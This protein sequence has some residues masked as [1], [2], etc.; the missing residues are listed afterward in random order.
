MTEDD[1]SSPQVTRRALGPITRRAFLKGTAAGVSWSIATP[2]SA[3]WAYGGVSGKVRHYDAAVP[4][5]HAQLVLQLVA[6]TPGFTPPVASRALGYFGVALY[7]S[8]VPGMQGYRSLHGL[9]PGFPRTP[10]TPRSSLH[11]PTVA[12]HALG[13]ILRNLFPANAP[14]LGTVGSLIDDIDSGFS[15]PRPIR[16]RSIDRGVEIANVVGEWASTDGG[17]GGHLTNFPA[18][19]VPVSGPGLWEPTPPALQ[20]IPL[21][22]F[23]GQNR[24]FADLGCVAPP[25]PAYSVDPD[26]EFYAYAAEVYDTSLTLTT[27]QAAIA[28]FWADDPGT[29]TPPGHSVSMLRQVLVAE[30]ASLERAAEAYLRVGCAVADA[31]IQ[32]WRTKFI[33]NLLRPVTYI[34]ANF[35]AGWSSLVTTPPFPE[36]S[37]GHSSQSGAW[38]EVMTSLFGDGFEFTDHT[39]DAAGLSPR[40]FTSFREAA[41]EAAVSRLYGGIHY[42]FGNENG[43]AAGACIGRAAANLSLR[44]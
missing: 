39:H 23:W 34:R 1:T 7:E 35:D 6:S 26:S 36:Y 15:I 29:I 8:L 20:P 12:N 5:A 11:W 17:H 25:P 40:S 33:W 27:E 4:N 16:S 14:M 9:L 13:T 41:E 42:R 43:L 24:E 28:R 37:S 31:F 2:W 22:P 10:T 18:G 44:A 3:P 32:C 19:Y 21:Q 38:A 30:D